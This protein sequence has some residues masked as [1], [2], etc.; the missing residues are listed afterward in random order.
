M[1]K[2][3][4]PHEAQK[5]ACSF[6][7]KRSIWDELRRQRD[8]DRQNLLVQGRV[9]RD[10]FL[11]AQRR[12]KV[13]VKKEGDAQGRGVWKGVDRG[14]GLRHGEGTGQEGM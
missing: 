11:L 2:T 8:G 6:H 4:W 10:P 7:A 9:Q 5:V 1:Q 12:W 13:G 14:L 3:L